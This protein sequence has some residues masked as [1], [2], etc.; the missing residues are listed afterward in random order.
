MLVQDD[1]INLHQPCSH[2]QRL[3]RRRRRLCGRIV[4]A[5]IA[6][7]AAKAK[8]KIARALIGSRSLS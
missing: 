4:P 8:I 2:A 7:T 6:D 5:S 1:H 3:L